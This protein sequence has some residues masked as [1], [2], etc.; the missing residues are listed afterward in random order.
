MRR[1]I[2]LLG[3]AISLAATIWIAYE[4]GHYVGR[5]ECYSTKHKRSDVMI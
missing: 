3:I 2:K 1:L 5:A 4:Y